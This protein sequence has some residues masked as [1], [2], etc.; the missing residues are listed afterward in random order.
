M[1]RWRD[2][3]M[4]CGSGVGFVGRKGTEGGLVAYLVSDHGL[5]TV[6]YNT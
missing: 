6:E 4:G 1:V 5:Y 3:E 2:G